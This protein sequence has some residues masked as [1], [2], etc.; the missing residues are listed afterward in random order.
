MKILVTGHEGNQWVL[1]I[2]LT[3]DQH[4][5]L[6]AQIEAIAGHPVE[7]ADSIKGLISEGSV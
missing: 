4:A 3:D 2:E 5:A 1:S 7:L 6:T